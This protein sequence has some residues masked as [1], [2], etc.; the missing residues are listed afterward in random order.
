MPSISHDLLLVL[1]DLGTFAVFWLVCLLLLRKRFLLGHHYSKSPF[2]FA[3]FGVPIPLIHWSLHFWDIC[4]RLYRVHHRRP[5]PSPSINIGGIPVS[6][7]RA[8]CEVVLY[9]FANFMLTSLCILLSFEELQFTC[10][11]SFQTGARAC[12]CV[13]VCVCVC[14]KS[15]IC[16]MPLE[17]I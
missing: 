4:Y 3:T 11:V 7:Q 2:H 14:L 1:T 12:E 8:S 17:T 16:N 9:A 13:C 10:R 15:G 6:M 5:P